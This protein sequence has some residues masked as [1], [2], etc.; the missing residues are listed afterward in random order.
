MPLMTRTLDRVER[1]LT[2]KQA[3]TGGGFGAHISLMDLFGAKSKAGQL[4]DRD[5]ALTVGGLYAGATYLSDIVAAMPLQV[6][7]KKADGSREQL[8]IDSERYIWGRPNADVNRFTFWHTVVLQYTL[9]GNA[10]LYVADTERG[11]QMWPI[12]PLRV[13]IG[14]DPNGRKVYEIDGTTPERPLTDGGGIVHIMGPSV[15]GLRGLSLVQLMTQAIGLS[16]SAEEFAARFFGEG[17]LPGGYISTDQ[18]LTQAQ[19]EQL[20]QAW[21]ANHKGPANA[22]RVAVLGKGTKW[23][24]TSLSMEDSQ[25]IESRKFNVSEAARFLRMP[26]FLL[27]SHDK[28]S[29]WGSGLFEIIQAMYRFRVDPLL[30]N[31]E[32]SITDELLKTPDNHYVRFERKALLRMDPKSQ[33]EYLQIRRRNGTLT[34]NE[35]RELD[36]EAP[37]PGD[38]GDTYMIEGNMA[39]LNADGTATPLSGGAKEPPAEAPAAPVDAPPPP[40]PK[41]QDIH[42]TMPA[43]T[44]DARTV[45]P[46]RTVTKRIERDEAGRIAAVVEEEAE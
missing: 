12:D 41:A 24:H 2:P 13:K 45:E 27:G 38:A 22:H 44:V 30:V 14:R 1:A 4:V 20:S 26:E 31:I 34:A 11:R 19:A 25:L 8:T 42:I 32:Q 36:D 37:I 40:E 5:K 28:E 29:S 6:H 17:S 18:P 21:E 7:R 33:A 23:M 43:I 15:D 46:A 39:I 35:W 9:H 16:L 3:A 10:F